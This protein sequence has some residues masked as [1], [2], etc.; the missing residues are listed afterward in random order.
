MH[1]VERALQSFHSIKLDNIIPPIASMPVVTADTP[2]L[3]VLKLLRARHHVW[4]VEDRKSMKLT[5]VIRYLDVIDIFLPP[6]AHKFKLGMTSRTLRSILG[7]AEKAEDVAERNV[8]T[9]EEDS[10][11]LD[12]LMKMRR[13][14]TQVLAV[15]DGDCLVGE[16]SLRILIDEFLRLLKVGDVKWTQHGSSSRSESL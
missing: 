15:V 12:A 10:T 14:R 4:V 5:G 9:I 6:E 16:V 3:T 1:D 2:L 11:V 13:Y 7:G 8:L